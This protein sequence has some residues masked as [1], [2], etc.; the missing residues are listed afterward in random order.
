MVV[1][2]VERIR[3]ETLVF[4]VE[5]R[6]VALKPFA[7]PPRKAAEHAVG[8]A[9]VG[10]RNLGTVVLARTRLVVAPALEVLAYA[11]GGRVDEVA[12]WVHCVGYK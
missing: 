12:C 3:D 11:V 2:V 8:D 1:A 10:V 4:L 6:L 7:V 5:G 9:V